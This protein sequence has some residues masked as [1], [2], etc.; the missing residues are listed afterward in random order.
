MS[1]RMATPSNNQLPASFATLTTTITARIH[2]PRRKLWTLSESA[3]VGREQYN[4]ELGCTCHGSERKGF[5]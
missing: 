1:V 4:L 5:H 3:G 2:E